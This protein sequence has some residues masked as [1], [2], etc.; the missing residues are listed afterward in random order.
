MTSHSTGS[1]VGP[2]GF[3]RLARGGEIHVEQGDFGARRGEGLGGGG[4]DG[5]GGAGDGGNLAGQ[6]QLDPRPELGLLQRPIFAIEHVGFGDGFEAADRFG[7]GDAFDP[8]LG[9]VGG[10]E[11]IPLGAAETEK[12]KAGDEHHAGQRDRAPA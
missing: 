8:G 2:I 7:V 4:A 5:A 12:A 3:C 6:R 10:D 1:A 9:D 11:G